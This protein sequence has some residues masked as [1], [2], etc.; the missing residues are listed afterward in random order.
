MGGKNDKQTHCTYSIQTSWNVLKMS[1]QIQK[2]LKKK[3]KDLDIV[4]LDVS[5]YSKEYLLKHLINIHGTLR[6][7][8][9]ILSTLPNNDISSSSTIKLVA[10][11]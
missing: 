8:S 11:I 4:N 7:Y 6:K 10:G 2:R 9:Y 1:T 5:D 3:L